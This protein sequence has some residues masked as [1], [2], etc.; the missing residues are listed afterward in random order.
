MFKV[1]CADPPWR[2]SD[3]LSGATRG[4]ERNPYCELFAR[5]QRP[6]WTCLGNEVNQ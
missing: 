2:F 1:L 6:G 3:K 4:A 5:R